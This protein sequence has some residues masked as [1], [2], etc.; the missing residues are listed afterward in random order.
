[1]HID[2]LIQAITPIIPFA[3]VADA[4]AFLDKYEQEDQSALITALYIG[5][6]HLHCDK[7]SSDYEPGLFGGEIDR[8]WEDI[9]I[10]EK[11]RAR[12]LFEKNTVLAAYYEAFIRST[13]GSSYDRNVF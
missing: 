1:M 5:R 8:H 2:N 11:D 7:L 4:Q 12:V 9:N 3:T 6:S 10:P 13:D